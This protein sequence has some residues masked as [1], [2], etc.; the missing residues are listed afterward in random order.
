MVLVFKNIGER[1]MAKN[2]CLVSLLSAVS[3][4]FKKLLNN[5]LIGYIE[6]YGQQIF[7][8]LYLI[9]LLRPF[10]RSEAA[11]SVACYISKTF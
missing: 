9:K 11:R 5:K 8:Q 7:W 1:C 10:N 2:Y 4:V 3:K 6:E